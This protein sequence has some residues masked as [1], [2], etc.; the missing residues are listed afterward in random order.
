MVIGVDHL[1]RVNTG[2]GYEV[3]N[4]VLVELGSRLDS[5]L[6]AAD[7][8]GRPGGDFFGA[9]LS[10]CSE[11]DAKFAAERVMQSMR[12]NPL[13]AGE[14]KMH[15]TAENGAVDIPG[16]RKTGVAAR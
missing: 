9:L 4:A 6:R 7:V 11:E 1:D 10:A 16:K 15:D 5:A 14:E 8:I 3:G 13:N 2:Y 12:D